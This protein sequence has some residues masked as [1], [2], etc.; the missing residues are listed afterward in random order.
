MS[1]HFDKQFGNYLPD[2]PKYHTEDVSEGITVTAIVSFDG[3]ILA[4]ETVNLKLFIPHEGYAEQDPE[5]YWSALVTATHGVLAPCARL[6]GYACC[7]KTTEPLFVRSFVMTETHIAIDT[8]DT[9][10]RL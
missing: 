1:F 9:V 10:F 7:R 8:P 6:T 5:E 4:R 3:S 2:D